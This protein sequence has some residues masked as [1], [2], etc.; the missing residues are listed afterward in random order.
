MRGPRCC[1]GGSYIAVSRTTTHVSWRRS[2]YVCRQPAALAGPV[3]SP[4]PGCLIQATGPMSGPS[5]STFG[6]HPIGTERSVTVSSGAS[7]CRSHVQ[8]CRNKPECRTL[9]RMRSQVQGGQQP[10]LCLALEV[11]RDGYV[12]GDLLRQRRDASRTLASSTSS[13]G[14]QAFQCASGD[15]V[16]GWPAAD[17]SDRVS[18]NA[19]ISASG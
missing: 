11:P 12:A 17:G 4:R 13:P 10:W 3:K 14:M 19:R 16:G 15:Q 2:V 8:S 7:W 18:S 9:I 1:F 6:P 5:R